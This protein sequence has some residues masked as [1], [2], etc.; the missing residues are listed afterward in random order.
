M[1]P[2]LLHPPQKLWTHMWPRLTSLVPLL[3]AQLLYLIL[4][5]SLPSTPTHFT[6]QT[7]LPITMMDHPHHLPHSLDLDSPPSS[8]S[9]HPQNSNSNTLNPDAQ[10]FYPSALVDYLR[11]HMSLINPL[12]SP[13]PIPI[14]QVALH[15]TTSIQWQ[16]HIIPTLMDN[17]NPSQQ[18]WG[19]MNQGSVHPTPSSSLRAAQ[20]RPHHI[21]PRRQ[22]TKRVPAP[23]PNQAFHAHD[24]MIF[25]SEV[26]LFL[27]PALPFRRVR[28]LPKG[29]KW[30]E[31]PKI[32]ENKGS[33]RKNFSFK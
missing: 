30:K 14:L 26:L 6:L 17:L 27:S 2:L 1:Q 9:R 10:P 23:P 29:P 7:L 25:R 4:R 15:P 16:A 22:S 32:L 8:P 5:V 12:N 18:E 33:R 13:Q 3:H 20:V 19:M 24:N 28:Q 21:R 31:G 11:P